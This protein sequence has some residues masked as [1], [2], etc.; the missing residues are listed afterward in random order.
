MVSTPPVRG[1]GKDPVSCCRRQPTTSNWHCL[2]TCAQIHAPKNMRLS[3]HGPVTCRYADREV[4][5][6][7]GWLHVC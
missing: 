4:H 3:T 2:N 5:T 6:A 1:L 7:G